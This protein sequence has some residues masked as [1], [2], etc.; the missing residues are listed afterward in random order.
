[1]QSIG[2]PE[3]RSKEYSEKQRRGQYHEAARCWEGEEG[4]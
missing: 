3:N 1:M 4:S 2:L